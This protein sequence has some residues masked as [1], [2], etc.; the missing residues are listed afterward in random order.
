MEDVTLQPD[1]STQDWN[2]L[3]DCV[4]GFLASWKS[5]DDPPDLGKH[6]PADPRHVRCLVLV[7]LIK[8][9]LEQ[10]WRGQRAPRL[11]ETYVQEFPEITVA[12]EIPCDLIYEEYH[13][14]KQSGDAVNV[15]QYFDRFPQQAE[16]LG[17]LLGVEAPH[18]TTTL[19]TSDR[20]AE[21][22]NGERI[23]DFE[24]LSQLGKGAFAT[25]WKARQLSMK[26]LVALKIS[27][28][29]GVEPETMAKLEHDH[30]VRVYDQRLLP[31]RKTRLL[32]MQYVPG[33][34]LQSAIEHA[35]TLPPAARSG[36]TLLQAV[37]QALDLRGESP[38]LDSAA[39]KRLSVT[40]WS[41]TA[42][43]LGARLAAALDYAHRRNVLHRDIK[44]ANILLDAEGHPK[45]VDFNVSFC[46]EL[47]GVSAAAYFG[48]SLAYMSPEQIAACQSAKAGAE[49]LDGRSDIYSLGIVLWEML[50]GSRPFDDRMS[51]AG[52]AATLAEMRKRREQGVSSQMLARL[53]ADCPPGLDLVLLRCL[54]PNAKDRY[55]TAGEL[56]RQLDLCLH[57]RAQSLL[58][59]RPGGWRAWARRWPILAMLLMGLPPNSVMSMVNI[60]FNLQS[61]V[62]RNYGNVEGA[63]AYFTDVLVPIVNF[64]L[65]P[66]GIGVLLWFARPLFVALSQQRRGEA[67]SPDARLA[68]RCLFLGDFVAWIGGALW[69]VAGLAFPLLMQ[70]R[71]GQA[72]GT[73]YLH[74]M[75][76]QFL[77]GLIG[78]TLTF[79]CVTF[80]A[81]R[82]LYPA[83]VPLGS[84][85]A[86]V[87]IQLH[88]LSLRSNRF[89]FASV[90]VF[91]PAMT[92][93]VLIPDVQLFFVMAGALGMIA[94]ILAYRLNQTI[95]RDLETLA[96]AA[97]PPDASF[98]LGSTTDT[99][100][101]S[102]NW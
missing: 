20:P 65:F 27:N 17:R 10:R 19:V 12:G 86:E 2:V 53:P 44:P 97:S 39:R 51:G 36:Q 47:E 9:D 33:G 57:P 4:D 56:A 70:L 78:S 38:P 80:F 42:C 98:G 34:T 7:E 59:S 30:I 54:Q 18:L 5:G 35:A 1:S 99:V 8:V 41:E 61:L 93:L 13:I 101:S 45:L 63:V 3:A 76:A 77:C 90:A 102:R 83:I 64:L 69:I 52:F 25:V 82:V 66:L 85:D 72:S 23:D 31:E 88:R 95:Q 28:D 89:F 91:F 6:V 84:G 32:Y 75:S 48:G 11:L 46:S 79:F 68:G 62:A 40:G 58:R 87:A 15:Q 60:V 81:L 94:F 43:R 100:R 71:T 14:R 50:T 96:S 55:A 29:Q 37:D 26:R 67:V 92:L 21:C 49:D 16:V 73:V 24:L 74:F 22:G